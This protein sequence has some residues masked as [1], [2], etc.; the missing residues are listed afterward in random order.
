MPAT[1][2][3]NF[4]HAVAEEMVDLDSRSFYFKNLWQDMARMMD[5]AESM[6]IPEFSAVAIED[7]VDTSASARSHNA[8]TL[9]TIDDEGTELRIDQARGFS[10]EIRKWKQHFMG[11]GKG[12]YVAKVARKVLASLRNDRDSRDCNYLAFLAAFVAGSSTPETHVNPTVA[13][14]TLPMVRT[15]VARMM[16]EQGVSKSDLAMMVHPFGVAN[17]ASLPGWRDHQ[18][19]VEEGALGIRQVGSFDGIPVFEGQG[20]PRS[21]VA[22]VISSAIASNVLTLT[23]GAGHGFVAGMEILTAGLTTNIT[24][25]VAITSVTATTIVV[26]RTASNDAANGAGT[27]RQATGSAWNM[28]VNRDRL[29]EATQGRETRLIPRGPQHTSDV[30][31]SWE[32][33]GRR[34]R[35]GEPSSVVVLHTNATNVSVA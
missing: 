2:L 9:Q 35:E 8:L 19:N 29:W 23:V 18:I 26:P 33:Y 10:G 17:I 32:D 3:D 14:L 1:V 12:D 13:A 16:S 4:T 11:G 30:L 34:T 24:S 27:V 21:R 22:A 20:V 31:Q 5:G 28:I 25:A 15:A 6:H 7:H